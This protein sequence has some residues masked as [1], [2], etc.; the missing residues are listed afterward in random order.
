MVCSHIYVQLPLLLGGPQNRPLISD[1]MKWQRACLYCLHTDEENLCYDHSLQCDTFWPFVSKW[2][3]SIFWFLKAA[4]LASNLP[5]LTIASYV[6]YR[7]AVLLICHL[8]KYRRFDVK[9][10]AP[11]A[12]GSFVD[13]RGDV[14]ICHDYIAVN[15]SSVAFDLYSKVLTYYPE[16]SWSKEEDYDLKTAK[17]FIM[18]GLELDLRM[19]GFELFNMLSSYPFD[20]PRPVN[21]KATGRIKFQGQVTGTLCN[22]DQSPG[23]GRNASDRNTDVLV[24]DVSVSGLKLNQLMLAPQLAGNMS[25]SRDHI[26]VSFN[27]N[28]IPSDLVIFM[29]WHFC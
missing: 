25:F 1:A 8:S 24:G 12:E 3:Q 11:K 7:I 27:Q 17:A 18:E 9:W 6:L 14:I 16:E 19:R 22:T 13:A 23:D 20:S 28:F 29:Q 10:N 26:K 2:Y 21:L 15:S 5:V 4:S